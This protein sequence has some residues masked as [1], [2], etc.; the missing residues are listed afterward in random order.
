MEN[1]DKAVRIANEHRTRLLC[2]TSLAAAILVYNLFWL[3]SEEF[4]AN[5]PSA[6]LWIVWAALTAAMIPAQYL[7]A[8][9]GTL[10]L[11]VPFGRRRLLALALRLALFV[12]LTPAPLLADIQALAL[13]TTWAR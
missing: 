6:R 10:R 7:L 5:P 12:V 2:S 13:V 3:M 1:Q 11:V 4:S 8:F 9:H